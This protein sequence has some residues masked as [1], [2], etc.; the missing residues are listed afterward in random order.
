ML[1]IYNLIH[2][3]AQLFNTHHGNIQT[4]NHNHSLAEHKR[5][6][7]TDDSFHSG[8]WP[9]W[10]LWD[11]WS[12][13]GRHLKIHYDP[14]GR[15]NTMFSFYSTG[16][17]CKACTYSLWLLEWRQTYLEKIDYK[18]REKEKIRTRFLHYIV[19]QSHNRSL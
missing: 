2:F 18:P 5:L 4:E 1:S 8:F 3:L 17:I 19:F 6:I 16:N 12:M 7:N 14:Q 13:S 9:C 15:H 10:N 11:S